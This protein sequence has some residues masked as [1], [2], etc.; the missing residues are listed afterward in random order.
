V[1]RH[2]IETLD[3]IPEELT[4]DPGE[5]LPKNIY[6]VGLWRE[7]RCAYLECYVIDAVC[8]LSKR[9]GSWSFAEL[10]TMHALVRID[11]VVANACCR[12]TVWPPAQAALEAVQTAE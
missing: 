5:S 1:V 2:L 10:L 12:R 11:G 8:V 4:T 6:N 9:S 7:I 3:N